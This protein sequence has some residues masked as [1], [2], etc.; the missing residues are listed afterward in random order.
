MKTKKMAAV[1]QR[2]DTAAFLATIAAWRPAPP[3]GMGTTTRPASRRTCAVATTV[4]I[5]V[6]EV[7]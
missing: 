7:A 4:E 3:A 6:V 2:M 5:H 1:T